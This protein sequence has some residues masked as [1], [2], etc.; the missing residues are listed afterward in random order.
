MSELRARINRRI[1]AHF[2]VNPKRNRSD[3]PL[4]SISFDDFPRSA[5][6]QGGE[7]LRRHGVKAT[8]YA[9]G[10]FEGRTVEGIEQY[11]LEDLKA[12]AAEGH[13]IA[14]H[15]FTHKAVYELA[16]R[17]IESDEDDNQAFFRTHLEGYAATGF[18]YPYGEVS[19]RTKLLYGKLYPACRGIRKG[20]NG[21]WFDAAQLKAVGIERTSWSRQRI[22]EMVNEA[23]ARNAWVIFFTHDVTENPAP[24]GAT[25]EMLEHAIVTLKAAGIEIMPVRDAFART[26]TG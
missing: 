3:R 2:P 9:V 17:A 4:A 15:T 19:P 8:F 13:E 24:Y 6:T 12:V 25:P 7:I 18:A 22:E 23:V 5:W 11:H 16:N 14:S 10:G 1:T 20:V 21:R 26:Q